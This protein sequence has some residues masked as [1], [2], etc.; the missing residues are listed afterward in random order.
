MS[1]PVGERDRGAIPGRPAPLITQQQQTDGKTTNVFI[2][3]VPVPD[4]P[5]GQNSVPRILIPVTDMT[6]FLQEP[7]APRPGQAPTPANSYPP[8]QG[9]PR[10]PVGR[11]H[12]KVADAPAQGV[13]RVPVGRGH[14]DHA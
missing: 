1:N 3:V 2:T 10:V 12:A 4:A 8:S 5:R 11:G 6:Q 13:A 9:G 7:N 14:T